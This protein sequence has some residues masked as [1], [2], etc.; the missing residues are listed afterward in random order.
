MKRQKIA[1]E[2]EHQKNLHRETVCS[3]NAEFD[4]IRLLPGDDLFVEIKRFVS[5][6]K[7]KAGFIASV[8]GSVSQCVLRPAGVSD[9][10]VFLGTKFEIVSLSGTL[11]MDGPCHLH[12]VKIIPDKINLAYSETIILSLI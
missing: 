12:M 5:A 11:E 4:V 9:P 2:M 6:R 1:D 8:V 10:M 7:I 3:R